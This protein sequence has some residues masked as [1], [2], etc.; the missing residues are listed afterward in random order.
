MTNINTICIN[1]TSKINVYTPDADWDSI[2]RDTI[3]PATLR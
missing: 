3:I 2:T 1:I